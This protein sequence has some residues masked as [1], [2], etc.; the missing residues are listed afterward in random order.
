MTQTAIAV[1][2]SSKYGTTKKICETIAEHSDSNTTF[3][4]F[5]LDKGE[6]PDLNSYDHI[7]IGTSVYA[8]KPRASVV[9]FCDTNKE[10]LAKHH[11]SLFVC[12]MDK[13]NA[14]KELETTYPPELRAS[15]EQLKFFEGE[16]KLEEMKFFD[17]MILKLMLKVKQS[18]SRDYHDEVANFVSK[19]QI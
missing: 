9:A 17:K 13:A 4:L 15:A 16:F 1:V 11:C 6:K 8:G 10:A 19:I 7:I 5:C 2:Y 14:D 12:G 3:D 18:V